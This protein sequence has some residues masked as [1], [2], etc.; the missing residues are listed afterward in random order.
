M[1]F[2]IWIIDDIS[3]CYCKQTRLNIIN[4]ICDIWKMLD[5]INY[6]FCSSHLLKCL[7]KLIDFIFI[8]FLYLIFILR[9]IDCGGHCRLYFKKG[10][11][12][13]NRFILNEYL[14]VSYWFATCT[15]WPFFCPQFLKLFVFLVLI[16][17]V[18]FLD[19]LLFINMLLLFYLV[20]IVVQVFIFYF[21]IIIIAI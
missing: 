6:H 19:L 9:F 12:F 20:N 4:L 7:P 17:N 18:V 13:I 2:N 14:I 3:C 11:N 8:L 1:L 5:F 21:I 10:I 15:F 16:F